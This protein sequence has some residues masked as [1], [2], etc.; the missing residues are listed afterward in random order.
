MGRRDLQKISDKEWYFGSLAD[1]G[2]TQN[3]TGIKRERDGSLYYGGWQNGFREGYGMLGEADGSLRVGTWSEDKFSGGIVRIWAPGD[4]LCVFFGK[5]EGVNPQDGTLLCSDERLYHG[6]FS[7][8]RKGEFNGEGTI[9]WANKRIYAGHWKN[10]GT[11][12]G[13]VIRRPDKTDG[14]VIGTLSNV[15]KDFVAKSWPQESD[16]HF[17]YGITEDDEIRNANGILFFQ[18]GEFFAGKMVGGQRSGTGLLCTPNKEFFYGNWENGTLNGYGVYMKMVE[19]SISCYIGGFL[20][21]QFEGEGCFFQRNGSA[22]DYEY[23]GSWKKGK[24]SGDGFLNIGEGQFFIGHFDED[25]KNGTGETILEDGSRTSMLWKNGVPAISLDS[26]KESGPSRVMYSSPDDIAGVVLNSLNNY[27]DM[28]E[29]EFVGIRADAESGYK[30]EML[31]E[32]GCDYE[33]RIF[34]HNDAN[35]DSFESNGTKVRAYYSK[36][37]DIGSEGIISA[38]LA[39]ENAETPLIWDGI[40]LSSSEALPLSYK[41]ASAKIQ[42]RWKSNGHILPQTFFSEDGVFIGADELN[43][44]LPA[45]DMGQVTFIIHAGG[46]K[47]DNSISFS[48]KAK[49]RPANANDE[50]AYDVKPAQTASCDSSGKKRKRSRV[51]VRITGSAGNGEYGKQVVADIGEE[52]QVK[53]DFTNSASQQDIKISVNIPTV[54][55]YVVGSTHLG[56]SDG[57]R[58]KQDDSWINNGLLLQNFAGDGEGEIQF[59]L[60]YFPASSSSNAENKVSVMIETQDISMRGELQIQS[61]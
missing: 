19:N 29:A 52:I 20:D 17:F 50:R 39:S 12:I 61:V 7:D 16:K 5:S 51:S 13:G 28:N 40:R 6:I 49:S 18:S 59:R 47:K 41:I 54:C 3:G 2:D 11:D 14:K 34:Y 46:K 10:G 25:Q 27:S 30:R 43:G 55:E 15:R 31:I 60:R 33:V 9:V 48:S 53:I 37:V 8:W 21:S 57:S 38:A 36:S 1:N 56:L 26:V 22:W 23:V 24:K 35:E 32:P 44:V 42:N 58:R 4:S 45:G